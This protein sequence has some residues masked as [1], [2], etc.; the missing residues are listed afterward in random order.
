MSKKYKTGFYGGK[1]FPFHLGHLY[2]LQKMADECDQGILILFLNGKD[3]VEY[4][5]K[6]YNWLSPEKRIEDINLI[7]H[8]FPNIRFT[9]LY[10]DVIYEGKELEED[11][12]ETEIKYIKAVI[13]P[14]FDA[15]YSS[16]KRHENFFKKAY[17]F[18]KHIMVDV[19]RDKFPISSTEIR[20]KGDAFYRKWRV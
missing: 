11:N 3:E 6:K 14:K 15:V 8:R 17:P 20:E 18:A 12:W 16:E 5:G 10:C 7:C 2:C 9:T 1:F 13:G 19:N 4:N